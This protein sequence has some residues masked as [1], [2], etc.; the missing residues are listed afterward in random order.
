MIVIDDGST[1][2]SSKI[3][4]SY[5]PK[6]EKKGFGLKYIYQKNQGVSR[7]FNNGMKLIKG[8]YFTW[9]DA[10]DFY[11]KRDS[12]SK[13]VSLLSVSPEDVSMVRVL[14]NVVN[15]DDELLYR[16]DVRGD[17]KYKTDLF[18]DCVF[19]ENGYWYP[20]GGKMVKTKKIDELIP[21]REIYTRKN[22][23]Q[24]FQIEFPI[25]YK[26]KCL[27]VYEYLYTIVSHQDSMSRDVKTNNA[28]QRAYLDTRRAVLKEMDL[29]KDYR[30]L[31]LRKSYD[32]YK[33]S[34]TKNNKIP[35]IRTIIR[36]AIKALLPYGIVKILRRKGVLRQSVSQVSA[37]VQQK[38]SLE[39]F[40][41]YDTQIYEKGYAHGDLTKENIDGW[42]LFC[43]H[44]L[45][46][47]MSRVDFEAGHNF[48]R[49]EQIA[50]LIGQYKEKN[51]DRNSF[52]YRYAISSVKEYILLHEDYGY[53][54]SEIKTVLGD[55]YDTITGS[56]EKIAGY[57][58]ISLA[59]KRD[60]ESINFYQLQ[61]NRYS[62]REFGSKKIDKNKVKKAIDLAMKAPS[63]CNRQPV[64]LYNIT[65]AEK[66]SKL[67]EIQGGF[68]GYSAPDA[69]LLITVDTRNYVGEHER[70]QGFIDGGVYAMSLL[71]SL[72][73]Y[74]IAA[75]PLHAMFMPEQDEQ[76]KEIIDIKTPEYLI[77]FIAIGS[78][79][80]DNKVAISTRYS[81]SDITKD[82]V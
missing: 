45:E 69:L 60:N 20:P 80:E 17:D 19:G 74:G 2:G 52:A 71:L 46:K 72:E 13:M 43:A 9:P 64:R 75:C 76:I 66:I 56:A 31:L 3:I 35:T 73:Y 47:A 55:D 82:I 81:E 79:N 29:P 8:E 27:T 34:I 61:K 77:M 68:G 59:S 23:G 18:E 24:N 50:N 33:S 7:T 58:N 42:L 10:D 6:F 11:T 22:A 62:V 39:R 25:L 30:R 26:Q 14:Y 67:L 49:L 70:N 53:S 57:K 48:F 4:Q 21:G 37:P 36:R 51:Y 16:I 65:N 5:I 12:I 1:D 15:Q 41:E 44:V 38:T 40:K 28:R 54:T 32:I 63:V 78:F